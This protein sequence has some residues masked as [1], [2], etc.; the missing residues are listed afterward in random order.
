MAKQYQKVKMPEPRILK[1]HPG[2]ARKDKRKILFNSCPCGSGLKF[3]NCCFKNGN[4]T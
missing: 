4:R 3:K 1:P 2:M